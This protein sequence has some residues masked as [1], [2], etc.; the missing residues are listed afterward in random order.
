MEIRILTAED[1]GFYRE[2]RIEALMLAS[3]AFGAALEEALDKPV[4]KTAEQLSSPA[5]TTF[6]A[7][8]GGRL[9][10]NATLVR[11]TGTKMRHRGNIV[12]VYVTPSARGRRIAS[13]LMDALIEYAKGLEGLEQLYLAVVKENSTAIELYKRTGFEKYGTEYRSMKVDGR[14]IDE[15]LMVKFLS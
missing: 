8:V 3:D 6:G 12:A 1:A 11:Q 2:L 13:R 10:G 15:D 9:L 14:Y 5:A 4:E 7:F